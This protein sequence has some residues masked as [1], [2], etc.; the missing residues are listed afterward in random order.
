MLCT[1]YGFAQTMDCPA[2]S[3]N[4]YFAQQ[5]MDLLRIP[6][7][8]RLVHCAKYGSSKRGSVLLRGHTIASY[9]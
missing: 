1:K 9:S 8:V 2:Q 5:S 3:I 7:I 4:R 6:W